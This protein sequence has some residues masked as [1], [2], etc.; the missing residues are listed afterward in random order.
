MLE[1]A[2]RNIRDGLLGLA[3]PEQCRVCGS[4]VESWDDGIACARCW[5]DP[6]VTRILKG[7]VCDK[8]G[9]MVSLATAAGAQTRLCGMCSLLPFAAARACGAYSGALEASILFLKTTP[10]ICP[11]LR[12]IIC[13]TFA[14]NRAKLESDFVM[15]VPL[16]QLRERQ[17]GFNQAAIIA[18]TICR[19]FDLPFDDRALA[20]VKAT[21]RHRAGLDA[22]DRAQSVE[23][24]FKVSTPDLLEGASVLLVD[25]VYTTG[26][27]VSAAAQTLIVAGAQKVNVLT[28]ARVTER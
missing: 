8:C 16:H 5:D 12:S 4:P 23:R 22:I 10:H 2:L 13:R 11:R 17:R 15:P 20:R 1:R 7:F 19:D 27:T 24:A 14:E 28:I 18:K 3:Y 9:F 25:D 26:S 6:D 21:E